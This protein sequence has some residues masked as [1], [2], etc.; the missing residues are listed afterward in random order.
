MY[1][2]VPELSYA[3]DCRRDR[4]KSATVDVVAKG[5]HVVGLYH[6]EKLAAREK[7]RYLHGLSKPQS[8]ATLP[9]RI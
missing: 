8:L 7:S 2:E 6:V 5:R 1:S 9:R 4:A 3:G